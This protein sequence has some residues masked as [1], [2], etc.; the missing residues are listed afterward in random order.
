MAPYFCLKFDILMIY[1][2]ILFLIHKNVKIFL[3]TFV[4]LFLPFQIHA[5]NLES[6]LQSLK[7]IEKD[8]I[9]LQ[10]E[11]YRNGTI[12][13][14]TNNS[15]D[16][17]NVAIF[18]IRIRD[19]ENQIS[20][21]TAYVEDYVFQ[22]EDLNEKINDLL[23]LQSE[24]LIQADDSQIVENGS[25]DYSNNESQ[26]LG[27]L[28]VTGINKNEIEQNNINLDNEKLL[29]DTSPEEQYQFAFDLLRSQKLVEAKKAFEEFIDINNNNSLSG[30]ASYWIGEIIYL[31]GDYKEAALTFAEAYQNYPESIK[32]PDILL[33]LSKSL[34]KIGKLD[35][36]CIT[37]NELIIKYPDSK[38]F[39]KAKS[40]SKLLECK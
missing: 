18:D 23:L 3:L 26:S 17:S 28:S 21:L 33:R 11:V 7:R 16:I 14:A 9:D 1:M 10:K 40:E 20:E 25:D 22:I 27:S 8:I 39:T 6:V 30:S 24:N 15:S 2:K 34:S 31:N 19:I 36:S 29:P 13:N 32:A 4:F 37:L 38:L 35:Q 5:E 12:D